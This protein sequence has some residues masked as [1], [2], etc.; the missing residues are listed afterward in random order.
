MKNQALSHCFIVLAAAAMVMISHSAARVFKVGDDFGWQEPTNNSQLYTQ[1]ATTNRFQVGDSLLFEYKNDESVAQVDKWG[2][3]H[4]NTSTATAVFDNG[5]SSFEL[6]QPGPFYF[7]SG[8]F[9]HCNNG[10][11][12][13]VEVMSMHHPHHPS[14]SPQPAYAYPPKP[15]GPS[16]SSSMV[17]SSSES[18]Q[19]NSAVMVSVIVS[20]VTVVLIATFVALFSCAP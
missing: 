4:C 17:P 7:I 19:P 10:Q 8:N 2:Y 16:S 9:N 15:E 18:H 3:Y 14:I 12:L 20:S 1:W 13:V 6:E 11:L 5:R